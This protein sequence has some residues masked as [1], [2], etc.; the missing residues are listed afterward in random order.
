MLFFHD[1][2]YVVRSLC[3]VGDFEIVGA[4]WKKRDIKF[5]TD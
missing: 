1:I 5:I 4:D 2:T 3:G